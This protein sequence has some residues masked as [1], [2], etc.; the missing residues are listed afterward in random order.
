MWLQL[1][2]G[3]GQGAARRRLLGAEASP[4]GFGPFRRQEAF[5]SLA[6]PRK[7]HCLFCLA[8]NWLKNG[9]TQEDHVITEEAGLGLKASPSVG[10]F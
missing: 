3:G 6:V 4:R 5:A 8:L 7:Q 2:G 9:M 1:E 10:G